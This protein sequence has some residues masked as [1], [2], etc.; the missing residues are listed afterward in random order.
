VVAMS[1]SEREEPAVLASSW[2]SPSPIAYAGP[3]SG[4]NVNTP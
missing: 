4:V 3:A 1:A 2:V